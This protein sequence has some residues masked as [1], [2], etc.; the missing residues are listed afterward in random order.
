MSKPNAGWPQ[1]ASFQMATEVLSRRTVSGLSGAHQHEEVP[2]VT[3]DSEGALASV[4]HAP[5][6]RKVSTRVAVGEF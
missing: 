3:A 1:V 2:A 4:H 6:Q 5:D